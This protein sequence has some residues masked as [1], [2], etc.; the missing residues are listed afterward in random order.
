[1]SDP[2]EHVCE[3][4]IVEIGAV[5]GTTGITSDCLLSSVVVVVVVSILVGSF[6]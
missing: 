3:A 6:V 5:I 1:L 2:S 4:A